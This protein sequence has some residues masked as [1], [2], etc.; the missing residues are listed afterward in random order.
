[1]VNDIVLTSKGINAPY[2]KSGSSNISTTGILRLANNEGIGFRNAA[3]SA[4]LILKV[5]ATN[6]LEYNG[7]L[8]GV[9][10]AALTASRAL[11]SDGSGNVSV[12]T[13]TTTELNYLAGVTAPTGSGALVLA[14]SPT[15]I[16]PTLGVASATSI[17]KVAITAPATGSTLV[18]ADGKTLTVSNTLT[19]TGTDASSVAFGTGGAVAY[20]AGAFPLS[21]QYALITDINGL[22]NVSTVTQTRLQYLASAGGT[23]GTTSTNLVFSTSPTLVTPT[24][25]V[26]SATS[27]NKVTLTAPA[28]G[29]TLTI[30]DG[31]TATISKT[32]TLTSADDTSTLTLAAGAQTVGGISSGDIVTVGGTQTLTAKTIASPTVT[33][34]LLLQNP[35]GAQPTLQFSEDPDNGANKVIVKAPAT[36]AADY[37]LTLPTDDGGANQVLTTDG[38]GGLSW[39][40][41]ATTVT[42]TRGDVIKRGVSAD[43]RLAIGAADTVLVSDGTDPSWALTVKSGTWTPTLT[44]TTNITASTARTCMYIRV[45]NVVQVSGNIDVDATAVGDIVLGISLPI[46]SNFT[47]A[48]D[49]AGTTGVNNSSTDGFIQADTTNDRLIAYTSMGT[50]SN[51]TFCFTGMYL[52]K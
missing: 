3:N 10:A 14:N 13:T 41:V 15:L 16:T 52:V 31:K 18:L 37:T 25:G 21:A 20:A 22:I 46:A 34:D 11:V 5:N 51:S 28:S 32:M 39:S 19:F 42:T 6:G 23:T 29:A 40:T 44:N 1:M 8:L 2:F 50:A 36:L 33:G 45:G 47:A 12:A 49:A 35:S 43:E 9:L 48:A 26:A 30:A 4:D 38:S 7:G 27:I 17:N 24:L